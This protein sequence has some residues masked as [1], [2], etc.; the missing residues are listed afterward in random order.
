VIEWLDGKTAE[1]WRGTAE[2]N[3]ELPDSRDAAV[4]ADWIKAALA[5]KQ[6]VPSA[7]MHQVGC[8]VRG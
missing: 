8:L 7:I 5:G 1:V 4:T 6:P 2:E 3:P